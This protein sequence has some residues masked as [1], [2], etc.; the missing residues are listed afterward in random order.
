[1][2]VSDRRRVDEGD[3]AR[4]VRALECDLL[5]A[6]TLSRSQCPLQRQLSRVVHPPVTMSVRGGPFEIPQP[7]GRAVEA[8]QPAGFVVGQ[9]DAAVLADDDHAHGRS[10]DEGAQLRVRTLGC[11]GG[12]SRR[13]L[14]DAQCPE[15]TS[16]GRHVSDDRNHVRVPGDPQPAQADR[17]GDLPAITAPCEQLPPR[18]HRSCARICAVLSA[19]VPVR[20]A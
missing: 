1:M 7:L 4:A 19:T 16:L 9:G 17:D 20:A 10:L 2:L 5:S 15:E 13:L 18:R 3:D 12:G 8:H 11:L 6:Q 14:V